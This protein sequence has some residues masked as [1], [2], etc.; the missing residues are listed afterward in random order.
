MNRI[1]I[2]TAAFFAVSGS[3]WAACTTTNA[4]S[5]AQIFAALNAN[6]LGSPQ[7]CTNTAGGGCPNSG[8][9]AWVHSPSTNDND[10]IVGTLASGGNFYDYKGGPSN[11]ADP[12]KQLGTWTITA[13]NP[14]VLNYTY[15]GGTTYSYYVY[16]NFAASNITNVAWDSSFNYVEVQFS[17]A[18]AT[19]STVTSV[20]VAGVPSSPTNAF[21]GTHTALSNSLTY[22]RYTAATNP[23]TVTTQ[24]VGTIT[25][26]GASL[27]TPSSVTSFCNTSTSA[28]FSVTVDN[29]P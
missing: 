8:T 26:T 18:L 3:A 1:A 5:D 21:N 10:S 6:S 11:S 25:F 27:A 22:V 2:T 9:M 29:S 20:V 15:T 19:G 14:G 28:T 13:G 7:T 24:G 16:G 17:P 4:L 12:P 23:G